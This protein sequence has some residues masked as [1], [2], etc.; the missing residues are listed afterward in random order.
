MLKDIIGGSVRDYHGFAL[1]EF[2]FEGAYAL[3]AEPAD[4]TPERRFIWRSEFPE[5]FDAVD[6]EML[7]RGYYLVYVQASNMFGC[8]ES[9]KI[10]KN[11]Y[12]F[13]IEK[14]GLYK[15]TII[16]G[17]SRGGL[18]AVNFALTYPECVDALYLDAPVLDLKSW[19]GGLGVGKGNAS[20]WEKCLKIYGLDRS[21]ALSFRGNPSDRL[22]ELAALNIPTALVA[23]DSD[24]TVPYAEN[25]ALLEEVYKKMEK[26]LLC[27][28][29]PGCDHHPHSLDDPTPVADFLVESSS[30]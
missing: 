27:I 29:K 23:G 20:N 25:G 10:M 26:K 4:P 16:F 1:T 15:K 24:E 14:V 28:I 8:P 30:I 13:L 22:E 18:Y 2:E 21:S 12:D 9:I 5:A 6:V 11:F 19:P 3:I 17:F 7:R